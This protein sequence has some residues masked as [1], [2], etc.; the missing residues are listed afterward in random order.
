VSETWKSS[1]EKSIIGMLVFCVCLL[2]SHICYT[3][4]VRT[5]R[6]QDTLALVPECPK[7]ISALV[8]KCP[9]SSDLR[10][11]WHYCADTLSLYSGT[12]LQLKTI[13]PK[14]ECHAAE[15]KISAIFS[16]F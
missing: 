13:S 9:D 6:H 11:V 14:L 1:G 15:T 10:T 12:L 3:P 8:T 5:L 16:L 2:L 7:D 4:A